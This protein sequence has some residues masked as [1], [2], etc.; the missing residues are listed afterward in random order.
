MN[1]PDANGIAQRYGVNVLGDA[2]DTAITAKSE[3]NGHAALDPFADQDALDWPLPQGNR[4][5]RNLPKQITLRWHGESDQDADRSWLVKHLLPESGSGLVSGQWGTAKTF[6]VLDLAAAVTGGTFA[7][8]RVARRGG[9]FFLAA[10]GAFEIPIRLKGLV[11]SGKAGAGVGRLP[12]VWSEQCPRLLDGDAL[13]RLEALAKEASG[14]MAEEWQLPLALVIVDTMSASAGFKDESSSAEG[15]AAMNVLAGLAISAKCCV[16]G[17]DH[18]GK[19]VETGTRGTSAKEGAA[20]FVVALLGD[21]EQ[22]GSI[23]NL[24]MAI[25]KL[26]GGRTGAE[27][28]FS[29]R[30]LELG[31]DRDGDAI[32]TCVIDWGGASASPTPKAKSDGWIKSLIT[33]RRALTTVLPEH[34]R[35]ERPHGE[36]PVVRAVD[37][38]VVRGEFYRIYATEG[39]TEE[40]QKA[41]KRKAFNRSLNDAA[42]KN[43]I[44]MREICGNTLVWL[45]TRQEAS[46]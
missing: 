12:F 30:E 31:R 18:F 21:R 14:R 9:V 42:N 25:R 34:G 3:G 13:A 5:A 19:M 27:T 11:V 39:E 4:I 10:E 22:S 6:V 7:G 40:Q 15:Q 46:Q 16:V 41:A 23:S 44:G 26:R 1:T 2:F 45:E 17:V 29:L 24:R 36:G 33:L 43:L 8:R 28:T 35:E 37:R 38:E 32:T 20:D